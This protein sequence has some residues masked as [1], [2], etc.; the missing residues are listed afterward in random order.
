M[1][2]DSNRF[3][4]SLQLKELPVDRQQWNALV[5]ETAG[6]SVFQIYEWFES[7]WNALG[8]KHDL[9][10]VTLWNDQTLTGIAPL[11]AVRRAGLRQLEFVGTPTADYQDFILRKRATALLPWLMHYLLQR[12]DVWDMIVL[13]NVPTESPTFAVLP[14][15]MRSLGLGATDFERVA[16]TMLAIRRPTAQS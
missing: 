5:A 3:V 9:F 11:K 4:V 8:R 13:R 16:C 10:I 2:D 14:A 6:A 15:M 7:W 12:R 1:D